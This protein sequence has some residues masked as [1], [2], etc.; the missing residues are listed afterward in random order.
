MRVPGS[1]RSSKLASASK[2]NTP[3]FFSIK[4][5]IELDAMPMSRVLIPKKNKIRSTLVSPFTSASQRAYLWLW[6]KWF[7]V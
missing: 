3:T 6:V 2:M 7:L 5:P 1:V 4:P